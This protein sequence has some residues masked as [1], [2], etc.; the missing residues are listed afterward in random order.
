MACRVAA[1]AAFRLAPRQLWDPRQ[2]IALLERADAAVW[3]DPDAGFTTLIG[4]CI[5]GGVLIGASSGD[6][7]V[8]VLSEGDI[9]QQATADQLKNPPVG[10]GAA[11]FVPFTADLARR[12]SVLAMSD[13]VWKYAG[14][15]RISAAVAAHRG[16]ALIAALQAPA[17]LRL[18][19]R[20]P[21]D[22]TV[23]LFEGT[24]E[25]AAARSLP[26][27]PPEGMDRDGPGSRCV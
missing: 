5:T 9:P 6:S 22:F 20:F 4:L 16:G 14:W 18:S 13:G 1:E 11:Q 15:D 2:W 7:A 25:R 27:S 8:L 23:V 19:G 26:V 21:D 3:A 17:R 12:W 24:V 10:S